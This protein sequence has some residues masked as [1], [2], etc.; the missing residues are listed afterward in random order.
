LFENPGS[1]GTLLVNRS[2]ITTNEQ[3]APMQHHYK[4]KEPLLGSEI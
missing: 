1:T 2:L 4:D 3:N